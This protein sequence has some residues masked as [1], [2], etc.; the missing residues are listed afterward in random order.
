MQLSGASFLVVGVGLHLYLPQSNSCLGTISGCI[1]SHC[2]L[3]LLLSIVGVLLLS[4]G[5]GLRAPLKLQWSLLLYCDG[6]LCK[7]VL[8]SIG[9]RFSSQILAWLLLSLCDGL[10]S[11]CFAGLVS[12]FDC[13]VP[14]F[15]MSWWSPLYLW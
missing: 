4:C 12:I 7:K 13:G 1:L 10:L 2:G 15:V 11:S 3:W 5:R 6:G 14:L 8:S 9:T